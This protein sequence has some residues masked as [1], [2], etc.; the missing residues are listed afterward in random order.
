MEATIEQVNKERAEVVA[1]PSKRPR[2][3]KSDAIAG[4]HEVSDKTAIT[5]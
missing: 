1:E 4:G 2:V 5:R 3:K